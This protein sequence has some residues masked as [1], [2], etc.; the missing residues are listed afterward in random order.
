M[1]FVDEQSDKVIVYRVS[2]LRL[3]LCWYLFVFLNLLRLPFFFIRG[4]KADFSDDAFLKWLS[5]RVSWWTSQKIYPP[6]TKIHIKPAKRGPMRGLNPYT[7]S[8]PHYRR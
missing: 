1:F 3:D 2:S 7:G 5:Q 6:G 4:W 8:F